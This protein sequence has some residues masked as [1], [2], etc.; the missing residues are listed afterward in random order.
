MENTKQSMKKV[1]NLN[2]MF[3]N[4]QS[5]ETKKKISDSQKERYAAIR[6]A[7]KEQDILDYGQTD[8]NARKDVLRQLLD[9]NNLS[10]NS[11]KQAVNFLSIMLQKDRIKE[12]IRL[13]INN[14]K[15]EYDNV[16]KA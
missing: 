8:W 3:G 4:K 13:E 12:I 1:G 11:V 2:P 14:L 5:V 9:R 6:K 15:N 7:L 16:G 10:F